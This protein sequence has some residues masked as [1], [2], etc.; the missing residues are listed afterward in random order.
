L[1]ER[2]IQVSEKILAQLTKLET[3]SEKDRLELVSSLRF[4]INILHRSLVGWMQWV[5]NPE[6][7]S[8][9][10]KADLEKMTQELT[11]FTE[12]FVEYDIQMTQLGLQKG[13]KVSKKVVKNGENRAEHF[14]V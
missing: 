14:Y 4:T 3:T 11:K 1:S 2:W 10:S 9:F 8:I 7:M 5:T 13:L 12:T 6:I